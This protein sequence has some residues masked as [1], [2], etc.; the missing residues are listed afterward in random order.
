MDEDTPSPTP[1]PG[2]LSKTP[3]WLLLGF[4]LGAGFV[5]LLP[6]P[7]PKA[8]PIVQREKPAPPAA[9][10]KRDLMVIEAV[11]TAHGAPAVWVDDLTEVALW[12]TETGAYDQFY[13]V[14]RSGGSYYYRPIDRLTRPVLTHGDVRT[15]GPLLFTETE[16]MRQAWLREKA[17]EDW[18]AISDSFKS[19]VRTPDSTGKP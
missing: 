12:N 18:R 4:I 1:R 10:K 11:F 16:A 8:P 17:Q 13:E 7:A 9:P 3:S 15:D 14:L 6:Q 19:T 2:Q 5:W